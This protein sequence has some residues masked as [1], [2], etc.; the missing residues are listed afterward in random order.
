MWGNLLWWVNAS[1]VSFE[2]GVRNGGWVHFAA[3]TLSSICLLTLV[4]KMHFWK[5]RTAQ[6]SIP[7]GSWIGSDRCLPLAQIPS[8]GT[9]QAPT[10]RPQPWWKPSS[11]AC[12]MG[13][14]PTTTA[15]WVLRLLGAR[16]GF[17]Q[18][19]YCAWSCLEAAGECMEQDLPKSS[20][21]VGDSQ[22]FMGMRGVV[23]TDHCSSWEDWLC[24]YF[25]FNQEVAFSDEV[26]PIPNHPGILKD[27]M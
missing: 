7:M 1:V 2:R 6:V 22:H 24:A 4:V 23:S 17:P 12:G 15:R 13:W 11:W 19:G 27:W 9:D 8:C 10:T 14:T 5:K 3:L 16:V 20:L 26:P 25:G 21:P 18:L